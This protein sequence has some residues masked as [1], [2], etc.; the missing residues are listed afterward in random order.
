MGGKL[1]DLE[2]EKATGFKPGPGNYSPAKTQSIPSMKFGTG[3]R[4]ELGGG[5]EQKAKPGPGTYI[6]DARAT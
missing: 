5:K 3:S 6:G 1:R 2:F 4:I